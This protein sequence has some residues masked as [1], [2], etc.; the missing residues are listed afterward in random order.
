MSWKLTIIE[1]SSFLACRRHAFTTVELLVVLGITAVCVGFLLPAMTTANRRAR[2]L[3]CQSNLRD[4][5]S[6]LRIY[7]G[8]NRGWP[9]PVGVHPKKGLPYAS[10]GIGVPPHERWP[11][12]VFKVAGAPM[13]PAYDAGLYTQ[14]PYQPEHFDAAPYT[15]RTLVCP[16]DVEPYEA[17]SYRLNAHLAERSDRSIAAVGGVSSSEIILAGEKITFERDYYMQNKDYARVVER[18]RHG[19]SVGSNQLYFDGHVATVMPREQFRGLD[20]WDVK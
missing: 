18:Y 3:H 10:F 16:A 5:G 7:Q 6:A 8:E 2:T 9:Y 14:E 15:P 11:M 13:P 1:R 12:K 19:T 4:L 20:P 17:H